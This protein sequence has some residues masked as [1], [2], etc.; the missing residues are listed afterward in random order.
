MA[1]SSSIARPR[2]KS[3]KPPRKI[4]TASITATRFV[5]PKPEDRRLLAQAGIAFP[6]LPIDA[7][8]DLNASLKRNR[9]V[10]VDPMPWADLR[11]RLRD[12]IL[13]HY[14]NTTFSPKCVHL[15]DTDSSKLD[16]KVDAVRRYLS[17]FALRC[18]VTRDEI[19]RVKATG[20]IVR[21]S[22]AS[23]LASGAA[24][25]VFQAALAYT[26]DADQQTAPL[27]VTAV[28][29]ARLRVGGHQLVMSML[30]PLEGVRDPVLQ[31]RV[32]PT[33]L[34]GEGVYE[35][36][37]VATVD[38]P[39]NPENRRVLQEFAQDILKRFA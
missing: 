4:F 12:F 31:V 18:D 27:A 28:H 10:L 3:A 22:R 24:E 8:K 39:L 5:V 23:M 1:S 9:L 35:N 36:K 14:P 25:Q 34:V 11:I 26:F 30:P 2:P 38:M 20:K 32:A 13:S 16:D 7:L 19:V 33:I 29:E 17:Q 15:E 21:M 6:T 37:A